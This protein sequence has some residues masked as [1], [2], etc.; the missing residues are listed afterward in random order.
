MHLQIFD[1]MGNSVLVCESYSPEDKSTRLNIMKTICS[2]MFLVARL[3]SLARRQFRKDLHNEGTT[4]I[5]ASIGGK[6]N[7]I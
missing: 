4:N 6:C 7:Q 5:H 3:V 1:T 2:L